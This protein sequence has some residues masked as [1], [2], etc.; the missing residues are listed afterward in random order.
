MGGVKFFI[1]AVMFKSSQN[2]KS[3]FYTQGN[4]PRMLN[5]LLFVNQ[6]GPGLELKLSDSQFQ[7][8]WILGLLKQASVLAYG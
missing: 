5:N 6:Q 3:P 8:L 4:S 7:N 1:Y 2:P